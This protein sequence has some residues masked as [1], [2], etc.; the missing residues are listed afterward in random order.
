MFGST[1]IPFVDPRW[2]CD[3]D[4]TMVTSLKLLTKTVSHL[5]EAVTRREVGDGFDP[6]APRRGQRE[7][8]SRFAFLSSL[9]CHNCQPLF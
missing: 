8:S 2:C 5:K 9:R 3:A 6:V 4:Y 1:S 7:V